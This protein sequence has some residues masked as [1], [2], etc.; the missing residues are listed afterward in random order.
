[1]TLFPKLAL[2]L[3]LIKAVEVAGKSVAGP[4]MAVALVVAVATTHVL[5]GLSL[6]KKLTR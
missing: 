2:S 4:A 5:T 6:R 3:L 1:M